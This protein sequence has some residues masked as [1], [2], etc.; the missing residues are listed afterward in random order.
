MMEGKETVF[1][2][3]HITLYVSPWFCR[4][5]KNSFVVVSVDPSVRHVNTMFNIENGTFKWEPCYTASFFILWK[6]VPD[7]VNTYRYTY[8]HN[9]SV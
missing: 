9:Y 8:L 7:K 6:N 3:S 1:F 4:R 2:T 5:I